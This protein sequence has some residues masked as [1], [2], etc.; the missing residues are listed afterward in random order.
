MVVAQT[1]II[2]TVSPQ[3]AERLAL[4]RASP[5]EKIFKIL[6]PVCDPELPGLSLWDLGVLQSI[7]LKDDTWEIGI[8]LTY[9]G[10]PAVE[11]MQQDIYRAMQQ[12]GYEK[13]S[14]KIL[15]APIWSSEMMSPQGRQHLKSI[16]IAPPNPQQKVS[17][18]ICESDKTRLISEFGSTACKALYQCADCQ[19][20]FDY[21]KSF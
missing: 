9:S 10:C 17:C 16:Q 13:V 19:E 12:A 3:Y 7:E 14:V 20:T 4:R 8:T 21:F 15:L 11:S 18:P 1:S 6:D 5:H 2:D